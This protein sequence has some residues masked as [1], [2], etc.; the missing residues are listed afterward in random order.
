M[1]IVDDDVVRF[2]NIFDWLIL[3]QL[4]MQFCTYWV[5]VEWFPLLPDPVYL[6]EYQL[7]IITL[8]WGIIE[9]S[10]KEYHTK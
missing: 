2:W 5:E 10:T 1:D 3:T 9:Q 7:I 8:D 4:W 6:V